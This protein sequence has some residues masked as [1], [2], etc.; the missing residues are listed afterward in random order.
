MNI[1][2]GKI[3]L[4]PRIT[5]KAALLNE[6]NNAYVFEI[7]NSANKT[8]VAKAIKDLYKVT[9]KKVNIVKLPKKNII[10]RGKKGTTKAVIKAYVYLNKGD[11]IEIA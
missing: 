4:K 3:L 2:P 7:S 1:H 8:S 11:K 9:P 6:S 10:S 5:E